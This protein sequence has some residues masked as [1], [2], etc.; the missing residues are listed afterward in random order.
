MKNFMNRE[1]I[2]ALVCL[3]F[4]AYIWIVAGTFPASFLDSVG[5]AKY[6][7]LLASLIGI[8]AVILFATSNGPVKPIKGKREFRSLAYILL[9]IMIYLLIFTRIGFILSTIAFL[10]ALTLYFDHREL[11]TRLKIAVP[12]AVCFS[13]FLYYF[14][15]KLLGVLL[16]SIVL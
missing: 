2:I 12:Y 4:A 10:L 13:V 16:P 9:C 15:A 1:R 3:A 7:R 6:P 8:T 11:K 5:P 14:F